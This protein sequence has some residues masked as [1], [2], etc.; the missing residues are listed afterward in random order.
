MDQNKAHELTLKEFE[1]IFNRLYDSLCLFA[2][3]YVNDLNLSEDI[4]QNVFIKVWED[5][6]F[7][8]DKD[9]I[10]GFLYTAV[11]NKSLDFLRSKYA[12]YVKA[13]SLEDLETLQTENYFISEAIILETSDIIERTIKSLPNKCAEVMRLSIENYANKEIAKKMNISVY[14]VKEYKKIAYQELRKTLG[15]LR[16]K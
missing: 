6:V 5:K 12:K 16:I 14:T 7:F 3:K 1:N 8:H 10:V 11:K 13:Y 15:Y 9:K 4:V 2:N